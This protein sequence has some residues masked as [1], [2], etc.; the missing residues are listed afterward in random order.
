MPGGVRSL[1]QAL[2]FDGSP[3]AIPHLDQATLAFAD[4]TQLT[5]LL[6]RFDL[7]Q[8][9]RAHADAVLARNAIRVE[10]VA[11][12]YAEIANAFEHVVLKGF[13]HIPEFVDDPRLRTQYDLDLFV[14]PQH[15]EAAW[16]TLLSLGYEPVR[17]MERLA[18]DHLPTMIRKTGWQWRG[19]YFDAEIPLAV[20]VHF[21]FWDAATERVNPRGLEELWLRRRGSRLDPVDR[22]GYAA[23]HLT[24]HLLR[25]NVRI[26]HVWELARFLNTHRDG[27]F[28]RTWRRQ[29]PK[30]LRRLEA[31]A[32]LLA[33]QWFACEVPAEARC[34]MEAL[35]ESV[36][37]WFALYGWSPVEAMFRP[38]KHELLLHLSLAGELEDRLRILCRRLLPARLPGPVD[39][40]HLPPEQMTI[41]RKIQERLRYLGYLTSRFAHH[42][43]LLAPTLWS[44]LRWCLRS[45]R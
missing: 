31:I 39:A 24:R 26:F 18:M 29:H 36:K 44:T 35:P 7:P 11:A 6:T 42:A 23:L 32:F 41:F 8:W 22:L 2:R 5:P 28:W 34:E 3:R 4:R 20:E 13:T 25:G 19:D 38:N 43:R 14:P 40:I 45:S 15:R 21:Q 27:E 9:A 10:R 17:G 12:A 37:R 16:R 30:S 33:V 1:L